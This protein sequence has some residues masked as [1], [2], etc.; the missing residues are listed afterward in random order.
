MRRHPS[1]GRKLQRIILATCG[2]SILMACTALAA[3][4]ALAFRTE[5]ASTLA[6]T[7][8]IAGSNSTAALEFKDAPSAR[9]I[10]TSLRAQPHIVQACIYTSDGTVFATYARA[11]SDPN[12][13]PPV[14][15]VEG[16]TF[17]TREMALFQPIRLNDED[18]GTIYLRSDLKELYVRTERFAEI[19]LIVMVASFATAFFLASRLQRVISGPILELARTAAAVSLGKDYSLRATKSGEDEV[20]ALADRFNEM[21]SQIEARERAL[22]TV[23]H[24]LEARVERRT[25]QLQEEINERRLTEWQ[26]E[27]RKSF[28]NSVIANS[29]VGIVATDTNGC[30]QM[31]NPAFEKL[32][33][34]RQEDVLDRPLVDLVATNE[35]HTEVE[36]NQD[37]V[38]KGQTVHVVA[39]RRRRD[40]TLVDVEAFIVPIFTDAAMTGALA[41]YQDITDRKRSEAALW[42][43]KEAAEA[44]SRAKSDFLANMSHE[45]RTPMNGIIGMTDLA[46]DTSLTSE[47]REYLGMVKSSAHSLLTLI[48]DILDFSKIEA[49]KLELEKIDFQLKPSLGETLKALALRAHSKNLELVWRVGPGV[50]E[51]LKGDMSRLRQ[52]L[53]NLVGNALKFTERGE[54]AVDVQKESEDEDGVLLHFR[55]R[56]TGIGIPK[57]KQGMIFEAFTQADSSSTRNYGGTGLGLAITSRLVNLIGGKLWVESEPGQGSTFHFTGYFGFAD[58]RTRATEVAD[59]EILSGLRILV[60]DD[61]Q[62]NLTILVE[63][64]SAWGVLP[65]AAAGG[66]IALE[67]LALAHRKGE[68]FRLVITDMQMPEMDGCSLSEEIRRSDD[69]GKVPILLLSSSTRQGEAARCRQLAV[70]SYLTKPVQPSQL[71]DAILA[72]LSIPPDSPKTSPAPHDLAEDNAPRL[73]VLL[74]EDNAVNRKLATTLLEKRGHTVVVTENGRDALDALER[75]SVDLVLMDVQMPVMDGLE[76]TRIIREK[77]Q[78]T[79]GHLPI[80]ALTAHA[81]KGDRERCLAAGADDYVAKPIRIAELLAVMNRVT[82]GTAK[83]DLATR[84]AVSAAGSS[85]LDVAAALNRVEGDRDLLEELV[86]LFMDEFPGNMTAIHQALAA[87][88]ASVLLRLAHT[89]KGAAMNLGAHRVAAAAGVLE[90]QARAGDLREA[91]AVVEK[92]AKEVEILQPD[93]ESLCRKVTH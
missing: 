72:A 53:V 27:E 33:Q 35:L 3:Y 49:G 26:L 4:D 80:I 64:L 70:A 69:F 85:R 14:R 57:E 61:N 40:G 36:S 87:G 20:G 45:I 19:V 51:F 43:A 5:L 82:T 65:D 60:V 90:D 54:V 28:L 84:P 17:T 24:E 30:V 62:T 39:Q 74:A 15:K 73:K 91:A 18:I 68:P 47:Q 46:L 44:A 37:K 29:P 81:M 83:P 9:E 59:P 6:A 58:S 75:E 41:L 50:P 12:F 13:T 7:A 2:V 92:L 48:N 55:V 42:Q 31:C 23:H 32:F 76:A 56:D 71:L 88:D 1:I 78:S 79:G 86:R 10:L 89:I 93:L 11:G 52:V 77:E 25:R 66:K 21:L 22:Q 16:T 38:L 34:Y 67:L 63:M 8:G